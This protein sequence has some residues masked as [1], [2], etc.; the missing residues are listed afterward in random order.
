MMTNER[1]REL[2][3]EFANRYDLYLDGRTIVAAIDLYRDLNDGGPLFTRQHWQAMGAHY[4]AVAN[5]KA[6]RE[7]DEAAL[8]YEIAIKTAGMRYADEI[9]AVAFRLV[10]GTGTKDIT[11]AVDTARRKIV[12]DKVSQRMREAGY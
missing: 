10:N 5:L 4:P 7:F 3:A 2:R 9:A 8:R 11:R 1:R 12:S 6:Q